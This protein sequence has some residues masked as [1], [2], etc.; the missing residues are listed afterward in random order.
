MELQAA[1]DPRAALQAAE[2]VRRDLPER[3]AEAGVSYL[4]GRLLEDLG[5]LA[6]AEEAYEEA[7]SEAPELDP[8]TSYRA[9]LAQER[10]GHPEVSTGLVA[11]RGR[12]EMPEELLARATELFARSTNGGD[13]RV[14]GACRLRRCPTTS[15]GSWRC[16]GPVRGPGGRA[17]PGPACSCA[18]CSGGTERR[19]RPL[20]AES[21][22]ALLRRVSPAAGRPW[23]PRLR[24]RASWSG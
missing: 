5:H 18:T 24:P 17:R 11:E 23:R 9:A 8:W 1:G 22:D 14:C 13:C 7:L 6:R 15:A 20:A 4:R 2:E 12:P 21:L 3:A 16:R 19:R 10:G